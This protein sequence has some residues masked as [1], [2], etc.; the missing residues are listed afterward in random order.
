QEDR[1]AEAVQVDAAGGDL[2]V[3]EREAAVV[4]VLKRPDGHRDQRYEQAQG[5]IDAE[6]DH[7]GV[8]AQPPSGGYQPGHAQPLTLGHCCDTTVSAAFCWAM[9]GNVS[10]PDG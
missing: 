2:H 7:A 6:R 5:H 9:L 1:L 4:R 10:A 3:V 8:P